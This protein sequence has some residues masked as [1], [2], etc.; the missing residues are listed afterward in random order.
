MCAYASKTT[1]HRLVISAATIG[2][3]PITLLR[4]ETE[5]TPA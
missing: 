2:V 5:V 4:D 1:S 3:V